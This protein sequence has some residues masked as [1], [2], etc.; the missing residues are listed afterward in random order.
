VSKLAA[1]PAAILACALLSG[2]T[3]AQESDYFMS[4]Q[5][6]R[7]AGN[8]ATEPDWR[9]VMFRIYGAQKSETDGR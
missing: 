7:N 9:S 6:E 8:V 4:R 5:P 3:A 1:V 2:A